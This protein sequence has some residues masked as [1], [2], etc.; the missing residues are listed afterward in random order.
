[1]NDSLV[2]K[3]YQNPQQNQAIVVYNQA[4]PSDEVMQIMKR[5]LSVIIKNRFGTEPNLQLCF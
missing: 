5:V 2:V 1:M 3:P 4:D